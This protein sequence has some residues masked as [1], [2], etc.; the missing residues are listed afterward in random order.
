M[1]NFIF[2]ILTAVMLM[3]P[4]AAMAS[5]QWGEGEEAGGGAASAGA[6]A[7]GGTSATAGAGDLSNVPAAISAFA[8]KYALRANVADLIQ[9]AT[10]GVEASVGFARHWSADADVRYNPYFDALRQRSF[11]FGA[12]FWPWYVYSGLWLSGKAR[13]QEYSA[14]T[15]MTSEGDRYGGSL[16]AGYSRML[17]RHLNLDVGFGL[18][19]GYE[20]YSV[21]ECETCGRIRERGAKYFLLPDEVILA[22]TLVF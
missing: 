8:P 20:T 2:L 10:L 21:Y 11:G 7:S 13:Y 18:W 17:G 16:T 15:D 5:M 14:S 19:G 3:C 4:A 22:L 12:R 1:R 6:S 9:G